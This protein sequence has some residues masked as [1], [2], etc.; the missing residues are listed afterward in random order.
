MIGSQRV[1][2]SWGNNLRSE[3]AETQRA[4]F[5]SAVERQ[6]YIYKRNMLAA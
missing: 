5:F 6:E 1:E 4:P 2:V 3:G